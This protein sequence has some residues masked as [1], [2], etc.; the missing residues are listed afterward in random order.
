MSSS[1]CPACG[2]V[3]PENQRSPQSHNHEFAFVA[4]AWRNLPER[5]KDQPWAQSS[6]HL[7]K[8]ALIKTG[9]CDTQTYACASAAEAARWAAN[10]RPL[11]EYSIVSIQGATV[12]RFTARSQ[13]KRHGQRR[14]PALENCGH[15]FPR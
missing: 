3:L 8:F 2:F 15:G 4:E 6:E 12:F 9:F 11:D 10:L 13:S 14:I 5:F 1:F 7:R